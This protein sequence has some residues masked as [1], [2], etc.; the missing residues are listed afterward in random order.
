M[1]KGVSVEMSFPTVYAQ[2]LSERAADEFSRITVSNS[3]EK[4]EERYVI[5][6]INIIH[7]F[8]FLAD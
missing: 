4:K 3:I 6:T 1:E 5:S 7:I 2:I 8:T